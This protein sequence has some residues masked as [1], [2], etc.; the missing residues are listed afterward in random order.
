MLNMWRLL[1]QLPNLLVFHAIDRLTGEDLFHWPEKT[2][3]NAK[4]CDVVYECHNGR[5]SNGADQTS[6][7]DVYVLNL[8]RSMPPSGR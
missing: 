3:L 6:S 2:I 5:L 7:V 8:H 4:D 1:G